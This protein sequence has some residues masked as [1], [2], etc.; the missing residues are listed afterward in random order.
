[1]WL[2]GIKDQKLYVRE[3]QSLQWLE[4]QGAVTHL[5]CC[6]TSQAVMAQE[7]EY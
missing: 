3:V 1:M 6:R 4:Q 7:N 5:I 2:H